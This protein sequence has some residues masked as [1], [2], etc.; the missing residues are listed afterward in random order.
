MRRGRLLAAGQLSDSAAFYLQLSIVVSLLAGSSAPTPLYAT[1]QS[2]WGFTPITVTLVFGVY[3]LAVLS[4]LLTVGALSDYIGRRPVLLVALVLQAT[5]MSMF[6]AAG[7]VSDLLL[8]RVLQGLSTGA[9]VAALGAGMLDI[10][11]S[12]G[13]VANSVSPMLGT[14]TGGLGS[15]LMVEYLP[16]PTHLVYLVLLGTFLLQAIGVAR[17]R[18]SS[19]RRPGALAAL[20]PHFHVPSSIRKPLLLVA[21]VA[22]ATWALAGF[23]GALAPT[24][25]G[26]LLGSR[27]PLLGGLALF[28]LAASGVITV[29]LLRRRSARTVLTLGTILL[30][31][32]VALTL[33]A[34]DHA[35]MLGFFA[36]TSLSGMGFG[37]GFQG[38]IRSVLPL[39][40]PHERAGVLS[41]IYVISYLAMGLPA[42]VAGFLVVYGGGISAT[43]HE[44]GAAV[45][46]LAVLA[47][48]GVVSTIPYQHAE[49]P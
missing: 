36:G 21:P 44:Y 25:L 20:H 49:Q 24:L 47:L 29:L 16:E 34:V 43:A 13:T 9:A 40:A 27:S 11:R 26:Q 5:T 7:G 45:M 18:E 31:A 8:A 4:A 28:V 41:V 12:K 6:A 33:F 3:A 42:V 19:P 48:A 15:G 35:S 14:A 2:A 32:G 17:M 30:L 37:A 10:D 39:A 22:V 23:Y 38:A 46:G 1:Y